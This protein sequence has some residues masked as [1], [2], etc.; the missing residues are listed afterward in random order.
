MRRIAKGL[1][2]IPLLMA[3]TPLMT[4]DLPAMLQVTF[5]AFLGLWALTSALEGYTRRPLG[6]PLRMV[7]IVLGIALLYPFGLATHLGLALAL[8]I[9]SRI[10]SSGP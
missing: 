2:V 4:G 1:Y 3:W 9:A 8:F 6:W 5:F 7:F 10:P